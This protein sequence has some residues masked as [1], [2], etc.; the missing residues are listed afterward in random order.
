MESRSPG[1]R[2]R[3]VV[4]GSERHFSGVRGGVLST[5]HACT[6]WICSRSDASSNLVLAASGL[7]DSAALRRSIT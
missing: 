2:V 7:C 6:S 1:V 3:L 4:T 5:S